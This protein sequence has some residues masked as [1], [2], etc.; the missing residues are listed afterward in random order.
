MRSLGP[1]SHR[2][3]LVVAVSL[4]IGVVQTLRGIATGGG[5]GSAA[6]SGI[7]HA[8]VWFPILAALAWLSAPGKSLDD[9]DS[10]LSGK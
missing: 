8:V 6:T 3:W 2:A 9:D 10:L 5:V 7:T 4:T 1:A